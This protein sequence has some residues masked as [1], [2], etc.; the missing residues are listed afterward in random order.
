MRLTIEVTF[1]HVLSKYGEADVKRAIQELKEAVGYVG[2]TV[3]KAELRTEA[4]PQD[5]PTPETR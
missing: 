2:G 3:V 1:D 4:R 5:D